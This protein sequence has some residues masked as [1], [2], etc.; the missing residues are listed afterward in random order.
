MTEAMR[1]N[2]TLKAYAHFLAH[3]F[4][5]TTELQKEALKE[6]MQRLDR[7]YERMVNNQ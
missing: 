6:E 2:R 3:S 4:S 1:R 7:E 5:D